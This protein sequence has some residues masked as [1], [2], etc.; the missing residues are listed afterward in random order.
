MGLML[1][2]KRKD[3]IVLMRFEDGLVQM[4]IDRNEAVKLNGLF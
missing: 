4:R 2:L 3:V 1:L